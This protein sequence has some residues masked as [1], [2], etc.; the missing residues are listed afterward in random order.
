MITR[1]LVILS[2]LAAAMHAAAQ[3]PD[4]IRWPEDQVLPHFLAPARTLKTI[5]VSALSHE[6]Q[7]TFSALVGQV[8]RQ[9][10]RIALL[11]RRSE[12]GP[13]TWFHTPTV[14][15]PLEE[16]ISE[17]DKYS[18]VAK[19]AGS[20]SGVVLYDAERNPHMRNLAA[21][22]A[23]L[24]SAL[25]VTREVYSKLQ[26]RGVSLPVLE[27][28]TTLTFEGPHET[29]QHLYDAY[30]P[31]CEKRFILSARPEGRGGDFHHTRDLAAACGAAAVWFDCRV[32]RE[33]E[34]FGK[35]LADMPAGNAVILGWHATERSGVTTATQF[36]IGTMPSDHFMNATVFSGGSHEIQIP[37]TPKTPPLEN[38]LY[39]TIFVSDGDNIQYVQHAMRRKWDHSAHVRGQ[40]PLNWTMAPGL[41]DIAPGILNYY[42]SKATPNDCFVCGPSGMGYTMPV[43]TLLE[44]G[45]PLGSTLNDEVTMDAYAK[46]T[47]RYLQRAGLRVITIWDNLTAMQ[48]QSFAENCP[49][50]LGITVQNFRDDP[51]VASSVAESG[52]R[53][54]KLLIPY[55]GSYDDLRRSIEF[56]HAKLDGKAPRF[57]AYQADIWSPL[58]PERLIELMN[59]LEHEHPQIEFVRAD[60]Y[61]ELQGKSSQEI[62]TDAKQERGVR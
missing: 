12:E 28:L 62:R 58:Q 13:E 18:L 54:E 47:A 34:L 21:T 26:E 4:A 15:L 10:P 3:S 19:F 14:G 2:F 45:A 9:Q 31:Q 22:A 36:G 39:V 27:D 60:H 30:W 35:F 43:N 16:P 56:E 51:T 53:F 8:N 55:A 24:R 17:N 1:A 20:V 46:L 7:L 23:A 44:P 38:K 52:L 33:R 61:F 41:V 42:Y 59:D 11:N 29:Y 50:V 5:D 25:P 32:P 57:A 48:R 40:Q 6:E 37:P 49:D